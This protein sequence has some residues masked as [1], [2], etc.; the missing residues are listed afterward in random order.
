MASDSACNVL[1][2]EWK[3]G[4]FD[5]R[6]SDP[7][8]GTSRSQANF[9]YRRDHFERREPLADQGRRPG[10]R[11]EIV[12]GEPD[13]D[14]QHDG[15]GNDQ[16]PALARL[17]AHEEDHE[18]RRRRNEPD[19]RHHGHE[20][21]QITEEPGRAHDDLAHRQVRRIGREVHVDLLLDLVL[22]VLGEILRRGG[23]RLAAHLVEQ[24]QARRGQADGAHHQRYDFG[25]EVP[26][27]G[28]GDGRADQDDHEDR[29]QLRRMKVRRAE[30]GQHALDAA[31]AADV[32]QERPH[33]AEDRQR[34]QHQHQ[35]TQH[36]AQAVA[37]DRDEQIALDGVAQHHAEDQRRPRPLE[38][39][40][41]P[42]DE[43]EE[44]ERE[45][46]APLAC[47]FEGSDIDDA[48]HRR[49][50]QAVAQGREPGELRAECVAQAG[51]EDVGERHRPHHG[52]GD[53]EVLGQHVGAGHQPVDQER[54]KQDRH[55]G[56]A[57]DAESDCRHQRAAFLRVVGAF[58]RDHAAHI[59]LA[60]G[61][62]R[63][64]LGLERVAIGEPVDDR[65]AD[66]RDR[67][68]AAADPGAPHDQPP[69]LEA[70]LHP[71]PLALV[72]IGHAGVGRDRHPRDE[73]IAQLR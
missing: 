69:V 62:A 60:E 42:A 16:R 6:V 37:L 19:H 46:V 50:D 59:A 27:Q 52:I 48:E 14:R 53:A 4:P 71:L 38:L 61:C 73:Q 32:L 7:A 65:G 29:E 11:H 70:V 49:Q 15:I 13:E 31:L 1:T 30:V 41:D 67:A 33:H 72:D 35:R 54:A 9:L 58:R 10:Q 56:A 57:G 2:A 3:K 17:E 47:R 22:R 18:Q 55:G 34:E 23:R 28:G 24:A 36:P 43:A 44:Q 40:H 64:L 5:V 26:G 68:D 8:I 39:L 21:D 51:A 66:A 45:Q 25:A 12:E 63:T 20:A